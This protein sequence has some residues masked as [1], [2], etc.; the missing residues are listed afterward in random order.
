MKILHVV[1]KLNI[2]GAE[3]VIAD[4][5][6]MQYIEGMNVD[7]LVL[8]DAGPLAKT[9]NPKIKIFEMHRES[10]FSLDTMK[11]MELIMT[12]YDIVHIHMRHVFRYVMVAKM[13]YPFNSKIIFHDHSSNFKIDWKNRLHK[14]FSKKVDQYI[15]TS[16]EQ[17]VWVDKF[18]GLNKN[19]MVLME[20]VILK[21]Y[22]N[23]F[24]N[25]G[26]NELRIILVSNFRRVKN[27]EFSI[28][29]IRRLIQ[30]YPNMRF[31][32]YGVAVDKK[33]FH[34]ICELKKKLD[35]DQYIDIITN[36]SDIQSV[37]CKYD[38]ALHCSKHETGPLVLTEYLAYGLPFIAYRTGSVVERVFFY[39]KE[40]V[41]DNFEME[42]WVAKITNI[43]EK[44][45]YKSERK[46]L[47]DFYK[48]VY[49]PKE[50]IKKCKKIYQTVLDS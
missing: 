30:A 1:D 8:L 9:L 20:N 40:M 3:K 17:S 28:R 4:L 13:I 11:K 18:I 36:Q 47:I 46:K 15:L 10:K 41:I 33:Y 29:L 6:N 14:Y 37:L 50:Y 16:Q 21:K 22:N 49:S 2:G 24:M 26:I 23:C 42:R 27:I 43:Y 34:E 32:I 31:D 5:M 7:L 35:L 12:T 38:L 19:K 44:Y 39:D 25:T 48:D 45:N